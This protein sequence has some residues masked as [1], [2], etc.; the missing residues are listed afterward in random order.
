MR[1]WLIQ[2]VALA[3]NTGRCQEAAEG[4]LVIQGPQGIG[5]TTLFRR[6]ALKSEWLAEGVTLDMKNKDTIIRA[7]SVWITELGELESTLKKD[8]SSLKSFIT[9][10]VDS[11]RAPYAAESEDRP[12]HTSFGATVN[13]AQFLKDETGD[14]RFFVV[15]LEGIDLD[16][17]LKLP[18][19]WFI[20]L[21]AEVYLWWWESPNGFRL[22][23]VEREHLNELNRQHRE[24]L[25]GEEEIRLALN[26]DLPLEQWGKFT[27]TDIRRQLFM[28][29]GGPTVQQIGRALAKLEREEKQ[30]TYTE[31][32]KIKTYT[33]PLKNVLTNG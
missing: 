9:Q 15:P 8:Q 11:I 29:N 7:T 12:R 22:S 3:H 17:L 28:S 21:W 30:I 1:K 5:K 25:P 14:R 27:S 13:Q 26:W 18:D 2:C 24:M 16:A 33:L 31:A 19:T 20:Q 4:V 32:H 23:C 10:K 6:L